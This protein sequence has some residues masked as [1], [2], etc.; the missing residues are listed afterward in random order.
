VGMPKAPMRLLSSASRA[1]AAGF[2]LTTV[3]LFISYLR[4]DPERHANIPTSY[5]SYQNGAIEDGQ[6]RPAGNMPPAASGSDMTDFKRDR[7]HQCFLTLAR[8]RADAGDYDGALKTIALAQCDN[9]SDSLRLHMLSAANRRQTLPDEEIRKC[10]DVAAGLKSA[11]SKSLW[12]AW[13]GF[14][15]R[16]AGKPAEASA[17]FL[18]SEQAALQFQ[19]DQLAALEDAKKNDGALNTVSEKSPTVFSPEHQESGIKHHLGSFW[20]SWDGSV[21]VLFLWLF[22]SFVFIAGTKLSERMC[23][24][25]FDWIG[26]R[27]AAL[28]KQVVRFLKDES[29]VPPVP[30]ANVSLEQHVP[31]SG[32]GVSI[33]K[34]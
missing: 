8:Y 16:K 29:P 27:S 6:I 13:I 9:C 2:A 10:A 7:A 28:S 31:H 34:N 23:N 32:N 12:M 14:M 33:A 19:K 5:Q 30:A 15:Y 22:C 18:A 1:L 11:E 17:A 24:W 20:A 26:K 4:F 25:T 21:G 3:I